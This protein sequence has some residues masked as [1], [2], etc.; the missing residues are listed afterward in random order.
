MAY[1]IDKDAC[2]N[3][4]ACAAECP[5]QAIHEKGEYHQIDPDTCIDCGT[6]ESL[7]PAEAISAN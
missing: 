4:G 3:C 7:C 5:V 6:C 1:K 2:T